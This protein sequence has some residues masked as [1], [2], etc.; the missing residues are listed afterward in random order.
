MLFPA[1]ERWEE[2]AM[3]ELIRQ[4]ID[5][6]ISRR[7]LMTG[8]SAVGLSTVAAKSIAQS[9]APVAGVPPASSPAGATRQFKGTGGALFV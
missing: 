4:Y 1:A 3:K 2:D 6:G 5:Q 8:L 7:K 9:L